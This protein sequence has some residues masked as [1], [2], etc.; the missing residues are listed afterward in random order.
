VGGFRRRGTQVDDRTVGSGRKR[1]KGLGG[2]LEIG[3]VKWD[4]L[5]RGEAERGRASAESVR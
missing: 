3:C 2:G 1:L 5:G 4:S